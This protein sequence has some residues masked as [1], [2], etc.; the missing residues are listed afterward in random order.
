MLPIIT[1]PR[2]APDIR[3][4]IVECAKRD[5]EDFKA[6]EREILLHSSRDFGDE[7]TSKIDPANRAYFLDGYVKG[8]LLAREMLCD[9]MYGIITNGAELPHK[10]GAIEGWRKYVEDRAFKPKEAQPRRKEAC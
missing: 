5:F 2:L 10:E 6:L 1:A 8:Y 7:E 4:I 9:A 3:E